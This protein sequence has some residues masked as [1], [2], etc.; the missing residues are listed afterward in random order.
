MNKLRVDFKKAKVWNVKINFINRDCL[1]WCPQGSNEQPVC[2]S[3]FIL[4]PFLPFSSPPEIK[5]RFEN[6]RG[7]GKPLAFQFFNR[8]YELFVF[9]LWLLPFLLLWFIEFY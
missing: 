7:I 9:L 5:Q 4:I 2:L 3:H 8:I 1:G 6:I